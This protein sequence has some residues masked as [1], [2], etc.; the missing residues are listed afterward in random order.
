MR[1]RSDIDGLR[2]ISIILVLLFH[3]EINGINN[4]FL[5]VDIF[6]IIS[7]FLITKIILKDLNNGDFSFTNFY[8][9]RVRR[10]FPALL[11]MLTVVSLLSCI[12]FNS[13]SFE[14]FGY[15][16]IWTSLFSSNIWFWTETGYFAPSAFEKP[17]LHTWSLSVEEQFYL[18]FPL[19]I[20]FLN[21]F[22]LSTKLQVTVILFLVS[23]ILFYYGFFFH[24]DATFFL[25]PTRMW[26]LLAGTLVA[27]ICVGYNY[28]SHSSQNLHLL[29]VCLLLLSFFPQSILSSYMPPS[30][31]CS[32]GTAMLLFP[33][34]NSK[35]TSCLSFKPLVWIGLISYSLYLWHWPIIVFYKYLSFS[36]FDL[37]TK[38]ILLL[39]SFLVAWLSWKYIEKPIR[40]IP[41]TKLNR[42]LYL[43][44]TSISFL[45]LFTTGLFIVQSKGMAFRFPLRNEIEAQNYWD[46]HPYGKST[47]FKNLELNNNF[48]AVDIIGSL[49][50]KPEYLLWGDSHAM[51]FIP[52]LELAAKENN[53][54]FYALTRS[55]NPPLI[56]YQPPR[57]EIID[58]SILNKNILEFIKSNDNIHTVILAC[59]WSNYRDKNR[60]PND[61]KGE[62]TVEL[63]N[64]YFTDTIDTLKQIGKD[65]VVFS[66]V[67]PLAAK[68]FST[69]YY[70]LK[71][72]Y[73]FLYNY[74]QA[75]I[76]TSLNH[77]EEKFSNFHKFINSFENMNVR[78]L[79]F[80]DLFKANNSSMFIFEKNGIPLYRDANHLSTYGSEYLS[81]Y[82]K[83]LFNE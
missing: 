26:Q 47:R 29:G 79:D 69:R 30:I 61:P 70:S 4:G 22:K 42:K 59:A 14:K 3:F 15:S 21:K 28:Q 39:I 48:D 46:W 56:N 76:T 64:S 24:P 12:F 41:I 68:D 32:L 36:S 23:I 18:V 17:L 9:R 74:S 1:Y 34:K 71:S 62:K 63:F 78:F 66:Q 25:L 77:Y 52:G 37:S 31:P 60:V 8:C 81:H 73:P 43:I 2:G 19:Y 67:P 44:P 10:L 11:T 65:V 35:I 16:L 45:L 75:Q 55:G 50:A 80:T 82:L 83:T 27:L 20:I 57:Q 33:I 7:G 38:F 49:S 58:N 6:F 51:A 72:N 54:S 13:F 53:S 40:N 5:G